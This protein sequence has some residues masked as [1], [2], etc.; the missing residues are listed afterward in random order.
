MLHQVGIVHVESIRVIDEKVAV[1]VEARR[2]AGGGR[3]RPKKA[4]PGVSRDAARVHYPH[5]IEHGTSVF[6]QDHIVA[7]GVANHLQAD[8]LGFECGSIWPVVVT[9]N[10]RRIHE[11]QFDETNSP[12][13]NQRFVGLA[14]VFLRPR[15]RRI[16]RVKRVNPLPPHIL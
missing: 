2:D 3:F 11:V 6:V 1:H 14:Q 12:F 15:M 8:T 4:V 7:D 5:R 16:K 13:L 10:R 9:L